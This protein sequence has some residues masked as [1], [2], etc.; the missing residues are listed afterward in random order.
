MKIPIFNTIYLN[1]NIKLRS[2]KINIK[3]LNNLNFK[4][5]NPKIFPMIELLNFLPK[6]NS[7]FETVIVA[8]NDKLVELFLQNKIRFIDIQKILFKFIK[9]KEFCNFKQKY[10][11]NIQDIVQLNHY[12]RL[13]ISQNVI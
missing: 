9:R 8:A 7:L 3:L 11:N 4:K 10:P 6:K 13:K 1:E 5:V 12:V 2:K